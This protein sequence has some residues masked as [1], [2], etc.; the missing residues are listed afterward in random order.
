MVTIHS[1]GGMLCYNDNALVYLTVLEAHLYLC[2]ACDPESVTYTLLYKESH[3]ASLLKQG[4]S[5]VEALELFLGSEYV[6]LLTS[7]RF[8]NKIIG[9][10]AI[11]KWTQRDLCLL[12][13]C[14]L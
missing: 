8:R 3:I 11:Q 9:S 12:M 5:S 13:F 6:I 10:G 2:P 1:Q 14:G 7:S 4:T